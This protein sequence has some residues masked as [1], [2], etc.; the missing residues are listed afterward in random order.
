MT[1][2]DLQECYQ[3]E[4][5]RYV[6]GG[7]FPAWAGE[8]VRHWGET[9][10]ALRRDP[11]RLARKL[12]AY[13]KLFVLDHEL[14]RAGMSW[15][16]LRQALEMLTR[17]RTEYTPSVVE[18]VLADDGRSVEA[19]ERGDFGAAREAAGVGQPAQLARL[20]L[21]VRLQQLDVQYHEVGG[22]Y[23]R[24]AGS[25]HLQGVVLGADEVERATRQP[26]PG[27]RAEVRGGLIR[28]FQEP[29]WVCE[30]R[31]LYRLD[32]GEFVDLRDPFAGRFEP[33]PWKSVLATQQGDPDV[34]E[35]AAQLAR[36]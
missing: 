32:T 27:G 6:Q 19:D 36:R 9:L 14:G 4:C 2:L 34:Q 12:D 7:D 8:V 23:D 16:E 18:A 15:G 30:W 35:I 31:Y 24:L 26:P 29:G 25:G 1:A 22:V 20:Q 17:L 33:G 11:L 21:A 13:Y 3:A 28:Q 5:E 10:A